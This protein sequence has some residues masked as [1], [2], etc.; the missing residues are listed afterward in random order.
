MPAA[1]V[2]RRPA[3]I[4]RGELFEHEAIVRK[5]AMNASMT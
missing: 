4:G 3:A 5:I 2:G 1:A